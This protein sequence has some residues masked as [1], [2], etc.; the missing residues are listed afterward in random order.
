MKRRFS[1]T[2][3]QQIVAEWVCRGGAV[4]DGWGD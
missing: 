2:L 4:P 3:S 1:L